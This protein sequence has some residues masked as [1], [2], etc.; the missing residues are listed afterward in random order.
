MY[1]IYVRMNTFV[2]TQYVSIYAYTWEQG[3]V[4]FGWVCCSA[5]CLEV[6]VV[7]GEGAS[8]E[9]AQGLGWKAMAEGH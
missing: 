5:T 9:N 7:Q 4:Y 1:C 2:S 6:V 8:Y 3:C